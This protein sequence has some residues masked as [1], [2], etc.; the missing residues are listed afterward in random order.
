MAMQPPHRVDQVRALEALY[1]RRLVH[2]FDPMWLIG[3]AG[4]RARPPRRCGLT[5]MSC[6]PTVA[7]PV[8]SP[9]PAVRQPGQALDA[10][11]AQDRAEQL[12]LGLASRRPRL[13]PSRPSARYPNVNEYASAPG[14]RNVISSVRSRTASRWRMSWYRRPSR[15][16][17]FAVLVDVH[18]VRRAGSLAVEEHAEGNRLARSG[19][20]HEV[21]VAR[22]EPEGDAP[23]GL[24]RARRSRR[25]I[26]HSPLRAQSL[27]RRVVVR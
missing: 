1:G 19:G 4:S 22:V 6:A 17:P 18:A 10:G 15:S 12:G 20:Q 24:V 3:V 16:R 9:G 23:A 7:Q 11:A 2:R 25:P 13:R 21:R 14:S 26:A 8:A 5:M 27:S